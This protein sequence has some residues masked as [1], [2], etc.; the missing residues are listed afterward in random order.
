MKKH[1]FKY[2]VSLTLCLLVFASS[3]NK[4]FDKVVPDS[5]DN[6]GN[7]TYKVPKVLYLIVDGA[8]GSSVRDA[9]TT[10]LRGLIDSAV[11]TWAGLSDNTNYTEATNWSD[12]L[13]GVKKEKHN[14]LTEDFAGNK[15]SEYPVIFERIKSLRPNFRIAS[16]ASS[17]VFKA[18]L[19]G[20][21]DVSE[22][23]AGNDDALT[24]RLVDFVKSDT[25]SLI[26]GQFGG[27]EAAGK[28]AGFD[29]KFA[30]YKAAIN[31]FDSQ[32]GDIYAAIKSRPNYKNENW[33]IIVTSNK[34]GNYVLPPAEDDKTI[35]SNANVN[36]FT[37]IY[38][39]KYNPTFIPRPFLGNPISGNA[40]RFK[41]DPDKTV[42]TL[43][44]A[45]SNEFN[46]G[47][48]DFTVSVKVKKGKTKNTSKGDYWY[49]WPSILGKRDR[50]GWGGDNAPG[51]PGWDICLF[52]NGW[53]FFS[54]G[55]SD[56]NN[57][58]EVG[59]L[60]FSGEIWHDL[61]FVIERKADGSRY[62]RMYT[63][64][65]KGVTNDP[66]GA[67]TYDGPKG[68]R[69]SPVAVDVKLRG[70]PNFNN[71]APLRL[72]YAPG[73]MDGDYGNINLNMAEFKIWKVALSEKVIKQFACDPTMDSSHPN[74][75]QLAGYW[76]LN[77]GA[78][79]I[80]ADKGPFEAPFT[81]S[82]TYSWEKFSDLICTPSNTNLGVLVPKNSDVPTQI[83]SWFN[84][85]RQETWG[86]DG[87]VW[88]AN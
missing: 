27:V 66:G 28:A 84:I 58:I 19:T 88:I 24:S 61:T 85:P 18:K 70:E 26:L 62:L 30:P 9:G 33:L 77:E 60:D 31:K 8:R 68:T 87:R 73:E 32:V 67:G 36:T 75:D 38:N 11:Y 53:R 46:F 43:S 52:Y 79:N 57:G 6:S 1:Q 12:M 51:N 23:F 41:G 3:C 55:G 59:G 86:L 2:F 74:Y 65:V 13:T 50:A 37:I 15:L 42:A 34:G 64:G 47:A 69:T 54:A 83:L 39:N 56:F 71:N 40:V 45:A 82:G 5:P 7:V 17:D 20:G 10:T 76:P 35:F 22:S 48:S 81:L 78:G 29:N 80:L 44:G 63:D 21:A 14:V 4:D 16:F 49:Q 72:G 25:A